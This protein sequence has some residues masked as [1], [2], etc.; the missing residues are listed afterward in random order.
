MQRV[1]TLGMPM[2]PTN[3]GI[4]ATSG[5]SIY[6]LAQDSASIVLCPVARAK[7]P[8]GLTRIP[9][10][11]STSSMETWLV[12]HREIQ[13]SRHIRLTFDHLQAGLVTRP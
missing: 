5:C 7:G 12:T 3:F 4:T 2:T 8:L 10:D 6:E 11:A 1:S 13:T 9:P